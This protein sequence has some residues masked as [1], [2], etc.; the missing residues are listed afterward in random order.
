MPKWY[1]KYMNTLGE[2]IKRA[3]EASGMSQKDFAE[4]LKV[5]PQ[6][7]W[8]WERGERE[9]NWEMIQNISVVLNS[10]QLTR[11]VD[12]LPEKARVTQLNLGYWGTV[13]DNARTIAQSGSKEDISA[14]LQLLKIAVSS[15]EKSQQVS[16]NC[17]STDVENV[18]VYGGHHNNY[19]EP[20]LNVGS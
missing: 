19:L 2:N 5:T 16:C 8:R 20:V 9:P 14:V 10:P 12:T 1:I 3:R 13:A 4:K 18:S 15:L 11:T 6:T 7:V 17:T